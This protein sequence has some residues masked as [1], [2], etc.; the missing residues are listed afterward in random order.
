MANEE[1]PAWSPDNRFL[2]YD[3][4]KYGNYDIYIMSVYGGEPRRITKSAAD[5]RMP[6]WS[7][8]EKE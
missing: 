4:N 8:R 1:H 6:A 3:S 5:E 2:T 7:P